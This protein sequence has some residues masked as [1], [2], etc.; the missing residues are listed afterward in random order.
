MSAFMR[1]SFSSIGITSSLW[2]VNEERIASDALPR[3]NE[4]VRAGR[5]RFFETPEAAHRLEQE[6]LARARDLGEERH[7]VP[8]V[9]LVRGDVQDDEVRQAPM[10]PIEVL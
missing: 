10:R 3:L 7:D 2:P 8:H 6:E 1:E 5:R 9:L 4:H